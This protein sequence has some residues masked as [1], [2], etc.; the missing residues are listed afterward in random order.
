[1]TSD[2]DHLASKLMR[3]KQAMAPAPEH[4]GAAAASP[5]LQASEAG[6]VAGAIAD[7]LAIDVT[8]RRAGYEACAAGEVCACP[9]DRDPLSFYVGFGAARREL[10]R[11]A[12]ITGAGWK[13]LR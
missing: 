12:R 3:G 2:I 13:V 7:G 6:K 9:A 5:T 11:R 4:S 10:G 1:M 8:S